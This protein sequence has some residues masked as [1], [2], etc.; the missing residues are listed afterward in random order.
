MSFLKDIYVLM[1]ALFWGL[2]LLGLLRR[3]PGQSTTSWSEGELKFWRS[4]ALV[5]AISGTVLLVG[6]GGGD[7]RDHHKS[8]P[9]PNC[10]MR[11]ESCR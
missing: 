5:L 10:A 7:E 8:D 9:S 1:H 4:A 11:P 6:C 2:M 3:N